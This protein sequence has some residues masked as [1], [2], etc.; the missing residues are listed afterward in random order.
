MAIAERV[1]AV[2]KIKKKTNVILVVLGKSCYLN[3]R[4]P[5][6]NQ[7]RLVI[8]LRKNTSVWLKF[9]CLIMKRNTLHLIITAFLPSEGNNKQ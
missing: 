9:W 1:Y 7:F 6:F 3:G 8:S 4:N 2:S 5:V